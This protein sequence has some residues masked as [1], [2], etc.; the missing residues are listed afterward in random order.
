M[1]E[2]ALW[3]LVAVGAAVVLVAMWLA[4][5][6]AVAAFLDWRKEPHRR[7]Y[8]E[9]QADQS[10]RLANDAWWFSES[11]ETCELLRNLARGMNVSEAREAWRKMRASSTEATA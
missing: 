5:M 7:S 3:V 1:T 8:C 9:G 4:V 2:L 6:M 11:P 10:N